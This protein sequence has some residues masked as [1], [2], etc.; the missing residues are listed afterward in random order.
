MIEHLLLKVVQP[1]VAV[2]YIYFYY[3]DDSEQSATRI[4]GC[5]LEQLIRRAGS[6]R[7]N[8]F[9]FYERILVEKKDVAKGDGSS[10]SLLD[11]QKMLREV[12]SA[13]DTIY[14]C[15]DGLDECQKESAKTFLVSIKDCMIL[16][17]LRIFITGRQNMESFVM[18]LFP[19]MVTYNLRANKD[20]IRAFIDHR[21]ANDA[22]K[23]IMAPD[24]KKEMLLKIPIESD[25]M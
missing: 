11:G 12:C 17:T 23:S 16:S 25:G 20:D 21:I 24:V 9:G 13:F 14:I 7:R 22:M 19:D 6:H 18:D 5:I 15:I 10:M 1:R 8:L 3:A 4:L 2:V